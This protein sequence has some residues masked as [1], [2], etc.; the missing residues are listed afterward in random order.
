MGLFSSMLGKAGHWH[1]RQLVKDCTKLI[2][3][4]SMSNHE[5]K[6][7]P[8]LTDYALDLLIQRGC[9]ATM[10]EAS[11]ENLRDKFSQFVQLYVVRNLGRDI[12]WLEGEVDTIHEEVN[13]YWPIFMATK[14]G[15]RQK[16]KE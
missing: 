3:N 4:A 9:Y 14:D 13:K 15:T 6:G 11:Y 5:P 16:I 2:T 7:N 8:Y 1:I 12:D 10:K